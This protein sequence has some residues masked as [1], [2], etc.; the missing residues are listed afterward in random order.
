[1]IMARSAPA[2]FVVCVRNDSHPVSRELFKVYRALPDAEAVK[3]RLLRILDESAEDDLYP[4]AL[5][6]SLELPTAVKRAF[7][8]RDKVRTAV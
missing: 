2:N 5:F 7:A 3:H 4:A 1:M 6:V 8:K